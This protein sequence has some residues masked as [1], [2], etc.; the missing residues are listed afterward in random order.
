M[1]VVSF[2]AGP[3]A[4]PAELP[5]DEAGPGT[6]RQAAGNHAPHQQKVQG[7]KAPAENGAVAAA[8]GILS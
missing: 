1:C 3:S 4:V 5:A 6:L 7:E 8:T 2:R